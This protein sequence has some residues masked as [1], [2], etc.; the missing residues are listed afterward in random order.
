MKKPLKKKANKPL[1]PRGLKKELIEVIDNRLNFWRAEG[2][3]ILNLLRIDSGIKEKN[4][5]GQK[6]DMQEALIAVQNQEIALLKRIIESKL[7][8][9]NG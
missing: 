2:M 4:R 8:D 7:T 5:V 3:S 9:N 6:A 1:L